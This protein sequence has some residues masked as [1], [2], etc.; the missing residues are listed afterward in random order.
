MFITVAY[1]IGDD[2]RRTK[3]H[4]ILKSYGEWTQFS[5]FECRLSEKD[6]VKLRLRLDKVLDPATDSVRFYFLCLCCEEKVEIMGKPLPSPLEDPLFAEWREK[7]AVNLSLH[8]KMLTLLTRQAFQ[9]PHLR[10]W[11]AQAVKYLSGATLN[12][13]DSKSFR[14]SNPW[15]GISCYDS[16]KRTLKTTYSKAFRQRPSNWSA[17]LSGIETSKIAIV[18]YGLVRFQLVKF[19]HFF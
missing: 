8:S 9:L 14:A 17:S 10:N 7:I 15:N 5:L 6:F 1:D 18:N 3:V 12:Y 4:K 13:F 19:P 16:R 11:F 2:R